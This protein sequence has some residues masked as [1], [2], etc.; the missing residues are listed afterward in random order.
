M[1]ILI[2]YA[3]DIGH[4]LHGYSQ[5][6]SS[7]AVIDYVENALFVEGGYRLPNGTSNCPRK[8]FSSPSPKIKTHHDHQFW[9]APFPFYPF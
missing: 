5:Y 1:H 4:I 7:K 3:L 9:I 2:C 6:L 8:S